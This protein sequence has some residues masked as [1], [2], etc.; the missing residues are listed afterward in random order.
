MKNMPHKTVVSIVFFLQFVNI[1]EFMMVMPLGPMFATMLEIPMN[2]VGIIVGSYNFSAAFMGLV[3]A[4]FLDRFPRKNLLLIGCAGLSLATLLAAFSSNLLSLIGARLLAGVFGGL[5]ATVSLALITDLIPGNY[6]ARA[7]A[8]VMSAFSIASILGVPFGLE[9]ASAYSWEMPFYVLSV[10][11]LISLGLVFYFVPV[12]TLVQKSVRYRFRELMQQRVFLWGYLMMA[13]VMFSAFIFIPNIAA[14]VVV[15]LNFPLEDMGQLYLIGGIFSFFVLQLAG[16]LIDKLGV[17]KVSILG[18][19]VLT[20]VLIFGFLPGWVYLSAYVI[21]ILFMAGMNLRG[22]TNQTVSSR[23]P[24]PQMRAGFLSVLT[25]VQHLF[26]TLGAVF[27]SLVLSVGE[28]GQ[29]VN[30]GWLVGLGLLITLVQP[31]IIFKLRRQ[32]VSFEQIM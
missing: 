14:Y 8:L 21:Y 28:Q 18:T 3:L 20:V 19:L 17:L 7:L 24:R 31:L 11:C 4:V 10:F 9:L 30:F 5:I 27:S 16:K 1:V 29:L 23:I 32:K 25:A 22:V 2:K 13:S 6:R 12:K 15:N 26:A